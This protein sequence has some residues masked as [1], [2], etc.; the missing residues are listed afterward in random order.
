MLKMRFFSDF[1]NPKWKAKE[2]HWAQA[3]QVAKR[4]HDTGACATPAHVVVALVVISCG[5]RPSAEY[6]RQCGRDQ[7]STI[8]LIAVAGNL[9]RKGRS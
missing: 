3:L 6:G 2:V 4:L 7:R 9:P 5:D 1:I 8:A